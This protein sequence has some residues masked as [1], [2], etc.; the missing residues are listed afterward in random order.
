M[1]ADVPIGRIHLHAYAERLSVRAGESVDIMASLEGADRAEARLVRLRHG[2]AH[3]D[4]PGFREEEIDHPVNGPMPLRHQPVQQGN[5]LRVP[6][7]D[8]RLAPEGAFTLH[9]FVFPGL[10]GDDRQEIISRGCAAR[11]YGLRIDGGGHLAFWLGDG[12]STEEIA[13][14]KRLLRHIW[15]L[16]TASFDPRTR[17]VQ[18]TQKAVVGRYNAIWS[19]IVPCDYDAVVETEATIGLHHLGGTEVLVGGLEE[20]GEEGGTRVGHLYSGKIDRFGISRGVMGAAERD[21]LAAGALPATADILAYWDTARGY[22]ADGIGD[23]VEDIGPHGLHAHGV[24]RPVRGQTGWNWDGRSDSF[25]LAPEQYGGIEFHADAL[26]DCRWQPSAS[27][28]LGEDLHSGVYA[29]RLTAEHGG[30]VATERAVFFVRPARPRAE[31]CFLV[32]TAT[33]LAYAN[34]PKG[35]EGDVA[36]AVMGRAPVLTAT[37]LEACANGYRFGLSTYDLHADGAGV[38]YSSARRPIFTMRPDYRL[39]GLA[40][41]WGLGAD[42]SVLAWL[43]H[44]GYAYEIITDEDLHRDGAAALAPYRVVINGTHCEYYSERMLDATEDY[45]AAGGRLL[46]LSGNGY[47][48]VVAFRDDEPWIVEVRRGQ[49]GSRAWQGRAGEGHL[50]TS[51]EPGGLWRNRNRAPQK[52]VGTGFASEGMDVSVPYRRRP[53]S[54]APEAAWIFDGVDGDVVGDFGLVNGGAVG[55]EIDRYDLSL[56]TPPNALLLASSEPLTRNWP[57]AQE[58]VMFAHPALGGDENPL[59]RCDMVYLRTRN[60]GAVFSPSSIAWGSALPCNGFD[61]SVSIIMKNVVD[62]F[63]RRDLPPEG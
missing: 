30:E 25:R 52:L 8:A 54:R 50:A 35:L 6:D 2:D 57:L 62:G 43:D 22:G 56:G 1:A 55:L 16:V 19:K 36:Q 60:G 11:G 59:V 15:Y 41:P 38:C 14:P 26:A 49:A 44:H 24:N 18:L 20:R 4:G 63:L 47:Y 39:P 21:A 37:D 29:L 34:G 7:P 46:Y 45:L 61:N 33:Y 53:D 13:A 3:P 5:F 9:A 58:E 28:R 32:P 48:W 27:L 40:A 10:P 17:R 31:I 23:Q 12:R 42:L 51:G